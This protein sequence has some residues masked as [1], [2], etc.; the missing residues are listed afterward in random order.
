MK[1]NFYLLLGLIFALAGCDKSDEPS[2][3]AKNE[4]KI[5]IYNTTT[6]D[7]TTNRMDTVVGTTVTIVSKDATISAVTDN[8]GVATF[9]GVKENLYQI[10]AS[11]GELRNLMDRITTNNGVTGYQI[12]GVYK[13][14]EDIENSERYA[15]AIVGGCK[16]L[17]L[18]GDVLI[19]DNDRVSGDYIRYEYQYQDLNKDGIIDVK[20]LSNGSLTLIDNVV[21]RT[22]Y[23]SK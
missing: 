5:K 21:Q 16:P 6:W 4:L 1:K 13:S 10:V 14:R 18:N 9:S 23:L 17:D 22:V 8:N 19:D 2:P 15:K 7:S 11:K 20:D 12:I 3:T